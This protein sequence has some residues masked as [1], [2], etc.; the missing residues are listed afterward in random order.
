MVQSSPDQ[1]D[2]LIKLLEEQLKQSNRQIE[3]LLSNYNPIQ[4]SR[5]ILY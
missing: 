5:K 1:N 2:K 3:A 4:G